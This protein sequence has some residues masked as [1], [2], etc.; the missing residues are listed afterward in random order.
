MEQSVEIL[1][2]EIDHGLKFGA[3]D[4]IDHAL[5]EGTLLQCLVK[6]PPS[7]KLRL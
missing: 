4:L 7:R 3:S 2:F 6:L 5:S 1:K